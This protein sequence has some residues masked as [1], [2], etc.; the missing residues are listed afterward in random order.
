M[1]KEDLLKQFD[2]RIM[3]IN[4][5]SARSI[6]R[7][8]TSMIWTMAFTY[9]CTKIMDGYITTIV[10]A[11]DTFIKLVEPHIVEVNL[12]DILKEKELQ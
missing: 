12:S 8:H 6:N 4:I 1:T 11:M 5:M 2:N 3:G 9:V 7:T 10:D